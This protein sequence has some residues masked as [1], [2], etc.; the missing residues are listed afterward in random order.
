MMAERGY[1]FIKVDV[2][3]AGD[4][5]NERL[6]REYGVKGVP[7]VIFLNREGKEAP[8]LRLTKYLPPDQFL[9]RLAEASRE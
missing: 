6:I 2:S 7:T 4:P 9:V 8:G 3:K 5:L 1:I